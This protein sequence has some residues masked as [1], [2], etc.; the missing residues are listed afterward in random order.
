[1][2][3][4]LQVPED[5]YDPDESVRA[6]SNFAEDEIVKGYEQLAKEGCIFEYNSGQTDGRMGV[7]MARR[8]S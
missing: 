3:V 5:L 4:I 7:P 6:I 2:K 1:M 8:R